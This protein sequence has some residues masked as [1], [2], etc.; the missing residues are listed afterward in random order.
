MRRTC[1]AVLLALCAPALVADLRPESFHGQALIQSNG[2]T[3]VV[4]LVDRYEQARGRD[5]VVDHVFVLANPAGFASG[6]STMFEEAEVVVYEHAVSIHSRRDGAAFVL[7]T[8]EVE[9]D[10]PRGT[11]A[12]KLSG[13]AMSQHWGPTVMRIPMTRRHAV[14]AFE[15][16]CAAC[17]PENIDP[18]GTGT[19]ATSC[20]SGGSGA[21]S[22]SITCGSLSGESCSVTCRS[23][24]ACCYC[25]LGAAYCK[26]I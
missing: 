13:A 12:T 15:S 14:E 2:A 10:M 9:L 22:C 24:T 1:I 7:S 20:Q 21:S 5:G 8:D 4:V 17:Y 3:R 23:G 18:D 26:C 16:D 6:I 19:G 11:D 25:K